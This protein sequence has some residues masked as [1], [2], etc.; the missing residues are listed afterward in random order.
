[1]SIIVREGLGRPVADDVDIAHVPP[2]R[3]S[4]FPQAPTYASE[5]AA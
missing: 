3:E 1:M 2:L 4:P 5:K